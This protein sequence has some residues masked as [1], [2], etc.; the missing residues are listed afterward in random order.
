MKKKM[1][2]YQNVI[3]YIFI[4]FLMIDSV[5][6]IL[7][8]FFSGMYI[9]LF[10]LLVYNVGIENIHASKAARKA[11]TLSSEGYLTFNATSSLENCYFQF[12]ASGN[13]ID[14]GMTTP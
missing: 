10:C 6:N 9:I 8:E 5:S 13:R 14:F 2:R 4:L 12:S 11:N 3:I 7:F 1:F